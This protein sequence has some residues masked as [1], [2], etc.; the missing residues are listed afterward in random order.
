MY[1]LIHYLA[2]KQGI[3]SAKI[4][5]KHAQLTPLSCV[6]LITTQIKIFWF[7]TSNSSKK[8]GTF[9]PLFECQIILTPLQP[10]QAII[11]SATLKNLLNNKPTQTITTAP[12]QAPF[13]T[14]F[15]R[16]TVCTE[17]CRV[18]SLKARERLAL[19]SVGALF[20]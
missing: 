7:S 8:L 11:R 5:I 19:D 2:L 12:L 13:L 16:R 18:K 3:F 20:S 1:R 17:L 14:P 4:I 9:Y 6:W 10:L 15:A